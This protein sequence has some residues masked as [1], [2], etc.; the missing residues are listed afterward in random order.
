MIIILKF[1]ISFLF[2]MLI[3]RFYHMRWFWLNSLVY[4]LLSLGINVLLDTNGLISLI[5]IALINFCASYI[6]QFVQCKLEERHSQ[7]NSK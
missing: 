6:G 1:L 4:S 5:I 2:G 3:Y 7:S